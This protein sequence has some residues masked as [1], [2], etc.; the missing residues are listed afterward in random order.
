MVS[1]RA[2][3]IRRSESNFRTLAEITCEGSKCDIQNF[4][5][6]TASAGADYIIDTETR[7]FVNFPMPTDEDPE[8]SHR[9]TTA[10]HRSSEVL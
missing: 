2:S 3:I 1:A 8:H 9:S 5:A 7:Y 6:D 4:L 10:I